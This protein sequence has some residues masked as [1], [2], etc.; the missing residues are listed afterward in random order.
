MTIRITLMAAACALSLAA[1]GDRTPP[2]ATDTAA[3]AATPTEPAPTE[4]APIEPVPSEPAPSEPAPTEAAPAEPAAAA[5]APAAPA[6]TTTAQAT[7]TTPA[8]M[9]PAEKV[10]AAKPTAVVNNCATEIEG[11]DAIQ[12]NVGSIVVPASCSQFT[13]TLRHVGKLPV[14]A[15][16]H[17]V[18]ITR[19]DDVQAVVA[20]GLTAGAAA[21]YVKAGDARIVAHTEMIGGGQ[22][23]SVT[24][25]ASKLKAG[26]PYTFFCSFPGHVVTMIGTIGIG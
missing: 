17:N 5:P 23:T 25:D 26:G 4:P 13:I 18:V 21:G 3:P 2:P 9:T 7:G 11:N 20:D 16:G 1:C 6:N 19:N 8:A 24:F 15:M 14:A 22:S 10:A 12:Y